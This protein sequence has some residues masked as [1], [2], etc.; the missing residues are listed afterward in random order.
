MPAILCII[1]TFALVYSAGTEQYLP[2]KDDGYEIVDYNVKIEV[3]ENKTM[4]ISE[5]ITANFFVESHGIVR[6]IPIDQIVSYYDEKGNLVNKRF[7]N[8]ITNFK[9]N[10]NSSSAGTKLVDS[11]TV[12]GYEFFYLGSTDYVLGL[13][14]Y[15]FSYKFNSGYDQNDKLDLFY[16]NV[17]G[18]GWDTTLNDIDFSITFPTEISTEEFKFYVGEYGKDQLGISARITNINISGDT[19]SGHCDMLEYGEAITVYNEFDEGYFTFSKS[20]IIDTATLV[21][22]GVLLISM[23]AFFFVKKR[24]ESVVEIVE[25]TAPNGLTPTEVGYL[26]DGKITGDDL[27]ALVVYWAS[28]GYVSLKEQ[29]NNVTIEKRKDLPFSAKIHEKVLFN[30]IFKSKNTIDSNDL[31]KINVFEVDKSKKSVEDSLKDCFV[32]KTENTFNL[33]VILSVLLF[34]LHALANLILGNLMLIPFMICCVL[35]VAFVAGMMCIPDVMKLKDKNKKKFVIFLILILLCIIVAPLVCGFF[36]LPFYD[37][38]G[39]RFYLLLLPILLVLMYPYLERYTE[40]GR[41]LLGRVRGLRKFILIAEKNRIEMIAKEQ[42]HLYFE[43]LPYAYVLGVSDVYM[44]KFADMNLDVPE[45]CEAAGDVALFRV[46]VIM[47]GS[48]NT[49]SNKAMIKNV[50]TID[51]GGSR[52][53]FGGG[54]GFSGG[55]LGGGGGGR[56]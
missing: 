12:D 44:Q 19:I 18:T 4:T 49:V 39:A 2:Q 3:D 43:I 26:N 50:S 42:P 35:M 56:W 33:F 53:S 48:M 5:E 17:I 29:N 24:K 41:K 7:D 8:E 9:Y 52:G 25:F 51:N 45:W 14:T 46:M 10:K 1:L 40:K 36:Y 37:S 28:K 32:H 38:F 16:F 30:E 22:F 27:S 11:E 54:G 13:Q 6:Y 21:L 47:T 55:G 15:S 23:I 20:N 34:G 31:G